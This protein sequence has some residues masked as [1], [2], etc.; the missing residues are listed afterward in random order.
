MTVQLT[1]E[2]MQ[3]RAGWAPVEQT[4]KISTQDLA[5]SLSQVKTAVVTIRFIHQRNSNYDIS[6]N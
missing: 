3:V 1:K 4:I 2:K 5:Q 6:S